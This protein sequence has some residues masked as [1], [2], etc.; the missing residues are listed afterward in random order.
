M[1]FA[2]ECFVLISRSF[3]DFYMLYICLLL[4]TGHKG[5]MSKSRFFKALESTL[6]DPFH[7]RASTICDYFENHV[8]SSSESL[9]QDNWGSIL[10]SI[11][12][13]IAHRDRLHTYPG[14]SPVI[15]GNFYEEFC[16][17]MQNGMFE[18]IRETTPVLFNLEWKSGPYREGLWS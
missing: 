11:R 16:Q 2:L 17:K 4:R 1:S 3:L 14:Q 6:E 9:S 7:E 10:R 5:S 15:Q 18:L 8:F 12:D 13:K